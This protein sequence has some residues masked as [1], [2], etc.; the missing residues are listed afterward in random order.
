VLKVKTFL[1]FLLGLGVGYSDTVRLI[2]SH[3]LC[4]YT[5]GT[6]GSLKHCTVHSEKKGQQGS[7]DFKRADNLD[8]INSFL[9]IAISQLGFRLGWY[10]SGDVDM[11]AY[12]RE[13]WVVISM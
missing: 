7:A 8:G 13:R 5:K 11:L 12:D 10:M 6:V 9:E 3:G 2:F 1:L 4:G